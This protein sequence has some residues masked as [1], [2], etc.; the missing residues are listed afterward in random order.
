MAFDS[1]HDPDLASA[2]NERFRGHAERDFTIWADHHAYPAAGDIPADATKG[3]IGRQ[4]LNYRGIGARQALRHLI[5]GNVDQAFLEEIGALANLE[6]LELEWPMVAKDLSPLLRLEKLTFLTIDSPRHIADFDLLLR[7]PALRTL[8]ITDAKKMASLDWLAEAHHLEVI[9][10]E[11][12]MYSPYTLPSLK[13]LAGLRSLQAFLG[14]STKLADDSLTALAACPDL[15][16]L[17]IARVAPKSDFERLQRLK[18]DLVCDWFRPQMWATIK[19][20]R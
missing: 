9:G 11:G 10:I 6:R 20:P 12:G 5:S 1:A 16:F 17:G 7:L 13:P 2:L 19:P 18:P 8:I 15:A 14:V 3:W 4:K